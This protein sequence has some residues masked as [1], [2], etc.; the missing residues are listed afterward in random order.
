MI[1]ARLR[2]ICGVLLVI[3]V[4]SAG[5]VQAQSG[6]AKSKAKSKAAGAA[7]VKALDD[8]ALEM[9]K[10]LLKDA[11][12]ISR[13]YE[14]AG[15]FERAKWLLEVLQKLDPKLPGLKEKIE[16]LTNKS[17]DKSEFEY[18]L[19][20]SRGWSPPLA[21]VYKDR[22]VRIEAVGQYKF[23]ASLAA[24]AD[25]L[26]TDDAGADLVGNLPVGALIGVI[27]NPDTKKP[28]RPFELN[29][30]REWTPQ[31]T[32]F[33]QLRVNVPNGHKSTGK[34]KV[35]LSGVARLST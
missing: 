31:Q 11:S 25:G 21:M 18:E 6:T 8:R 14:D 19:D 4:L 23:E 27:I 32:G 29:A 24:G 1:D 34:L 22:L 16:D 35:Q 33:L 2:R 5:G 17:L 7:A 15:E 9:Q 13:G 10:G 20:V 28:G 26:P 12:E 30:K 3:G